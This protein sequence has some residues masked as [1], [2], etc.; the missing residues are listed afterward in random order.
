MTDNEVI[1]DI[2]RQGSAL[3]W[4]QL[5]DEV[6]V[7]RLRYQ[8]VVRDP[9]ARL[10]AL[11][12]FFHCLSLVVVSLIPPNIKDIPRNGSQWVTLTRRRMHSSMSPVQLTNCAANIPC[13]CV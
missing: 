12:H 7:D 9:A 1:A 6:L 2:C 11:T 5:F 3:D 8:A 10:T 13:V 4:K